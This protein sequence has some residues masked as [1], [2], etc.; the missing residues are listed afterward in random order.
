[1]SS[2]QH[3]SVEGVVDAALAAAG[4]HGADDVVVVVRRADATNLR[5]AANQLTTTG[6]TT[7]SSVGVVV[8]R[9][10][11]QGRAYG[12]LTRQVADLEDVDRLVADA[13]DAASRADAA[14]DAAAL[15][16]GPVSADFA[17]EPE[18][19]SPERLAGTAQQLG[20][21]FAESQAAVGRCSASPSTG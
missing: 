1:M 8:V 16:A 13:A 2:R 15:P 6:I 14:E 3:P 5:W 17:D 4:R 12:G 18:E 21:L 20:E 11:E 19:A 7:T 9:D 10:L